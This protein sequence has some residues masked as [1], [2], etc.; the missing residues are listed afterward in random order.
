[1]YP[2]VRVVR[3]VEALPADFQQR[4]VNLC[5]AVV[6][7]FVDTVPND[8]INGKFLLENRSFIRVRGVCRGVFG[9]GP[10]DSISPTLSLG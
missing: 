7:V 4:F 9:A 2:L 8:A 6:R 5:C 10:L 1:M 3:W